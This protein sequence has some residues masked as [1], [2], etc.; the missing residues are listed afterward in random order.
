[1]AA[2]TT[3]DPRPRPRPRSPSVLA[4]A[5]ALLQSLVERSGRR[6]IFR[7]RRLTRVLIVVAMRQNEELHLDGVGNVSGRA[8]L[9]EGNGHS[10]VNLALNHMA[11]DVVLLYSCIERLPPARPEE[12]RK[13][14]GGLESLHDVQE[15]VRGKRAVAGVQLCQGVVV[16][17]GRHPVRQKRGAVI[18]ECWRAKQSNAPHKDLS[19]TDHERAEESLELLDGEAVLADVYVVEGHTLTLVGQI[20]QFATELLEE[21]IYQL[22]VPKLLSRCDSHGGRG[23]PY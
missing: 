8:I 22:R 23:P 7:R 9:L 14:R 16:R 6:G 5:L 21:V 11:L 3:P 2:T 15:S 4:L 10:F 17:H 12:V 1:M 19:V 13:S 18:V 20:A